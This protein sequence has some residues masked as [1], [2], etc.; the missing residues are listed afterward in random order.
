MHSERGFLMQD[1]CFAFIN[2]LGRLVDE[3]QSRISTYGY[4]H[5]AANKVGYWIGCLAL[6]YAVLQQAL[7]NLLRGTPDQLFQRVVPARCLFAAAS[8]FVLRF[9]FG[10]AIIQRDICR[11]AY[12]RS[13]AEENQ[14]PDLR[15]RETLAMA[16]VRTLPFR[17]ISLS[18][19]ALAFGTY[20]GQALNPLSSN[21]HDC[22]SRIC[23]AFAFLAELGVGHEIQLDSGELAFVR[24]RWALL[25][26]TARESI[27]I[28]GASP[29]MFGSAFSDVKLLLEWQ[30]AEPGG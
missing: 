30:S 26:R 5:G 19:V 6:E 29:R 10:H 15:D 16:I 3:F 1:G 12:D 7:G 21:Q 2:L 20:V 8:F 14:T 18:D 28:A 27:L 24:H 11:Q 9:L 23:S 13:D 22:V 25:R 4:L 17:I